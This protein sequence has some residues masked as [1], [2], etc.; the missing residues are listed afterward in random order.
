MSHKYSWDHFLGNIE[1]IPNCRYRDNNLQ[2]KMTSMNLSE[3]SS[4]KLLS[5]E[6]NSS[7]IPHYNYNTLN[8]NLEKK[9][10]IN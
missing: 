5:I 3:A 4:S 2:D 6:H 9:K 10:S 1:D 7:W 8:N